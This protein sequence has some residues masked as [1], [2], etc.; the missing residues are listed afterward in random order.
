MKTGG[1]DR[2]TAAHL[3]QAGRHPGQIAAN[4]HQCLLSGGTASETGPYPITGTSHPT[5]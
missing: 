3:S 2:G 5:S 1:T 4:P